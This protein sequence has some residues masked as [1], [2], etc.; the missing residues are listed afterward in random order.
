MP[1][2]GTIINFIGV[3]VAGFLGA[4]VA[5]SVKTRDTKGIDMDTVT[6]CEWD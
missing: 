1:F 5:M 4:L 6:G 2:L 3:L